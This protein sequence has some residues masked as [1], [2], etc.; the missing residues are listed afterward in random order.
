MAYPFTKMPTLGEFLARASAYGV[1]V[2]VSASRVVGPRGEITFRYARR[3]DGPPVIIPD[4]DDE[5]LTPIALSNFCRQLNVPPD[6][7]GLVIGA[8]ADSQRHEGMT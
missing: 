1:T 5:V 6:E 2:A 7:F 8:I 3:G 4:S